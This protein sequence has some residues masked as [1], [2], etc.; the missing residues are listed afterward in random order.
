MIAIDPSAL[1]LLLAFGWLI[2][3]YMRKSKNKQPSL[4]YSRVGVLKEL[5]GTFKSACA[6]GLPW[7]GLLGLLFL[8]L[9]FVDPHLERYSQVK[10]LPPEEGRA[11]FLLVDRSGS[12]GAQ[13]EKV[14]QDG[15]WKSETKLEKLKKVTVP[16]IKKHPEDLFG[17]V[18]FARKADVLSPLTLD[19]AELISELLKVKPETENDKNGTAIGYA[20]YKTAHLIQSGQASG[21]PYKIVD[22]VIIILTDGLQD[23]N[24]LD[25]ANTYRTK[26]LEEAARF[27]KEKGVRVYMVNMEPKLLEK[28][29]A[30]NL[31][32]MERATSM[33]GGK[34]V[35]AQGVEHVAEALKEIESLEKSVI[36][37]PRPASKVEK[38]SFAP[39][40]IAM[41]LLFLICG[42]L[43]G[44]TW[45]RSLP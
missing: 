12:M 32:E 36:D 4:Y 41:G 5:D 6:R 14:Y 29:F 24:R 2:W 31:K 45:L 23:P 18:V 13:G 44:E 11:V 35:F 42:Y 37:V 8:I 30:P 20:L 39:C 22:P 17:L 34:V 33:T 38:V 40:F 3:F 15:E 16:F 1:I 9:A 43:A 19:H 25:F 27:A 26:G 10:R 28:E 7:V 21:S